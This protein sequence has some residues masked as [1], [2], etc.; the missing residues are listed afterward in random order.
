MNRRVSGLRTPERC[1]TGAKFAVEGI[2][3]SLL[4]NGAAAIALMAFANA[5][6]ESVRALKTASFLFAR[7]LTPDTA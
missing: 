1:H 3:T 7:L 5:H 2:K 6:P 4:L